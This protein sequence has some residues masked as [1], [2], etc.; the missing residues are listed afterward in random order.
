MILLLLLLLLSYSITKLGSNNISFSFFNFWNLLCSRD[1]N[2]NKAF[3]LSCAIPAKKTQI[4]FIIN[5]CHVVLFC[6][7]LFFLGGGDKTYLQDSYKIL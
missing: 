6:F 5:N 2:E 7:V 4:L 1:F 3:C